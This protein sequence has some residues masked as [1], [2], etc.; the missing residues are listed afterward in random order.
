VIVE[1]DL[2]G[3]QEGGAHGIHPAV[4]PLPEDTFDQSKEA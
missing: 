1:P 4:E 3:I 2:S